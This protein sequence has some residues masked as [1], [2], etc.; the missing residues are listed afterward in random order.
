MD[1]APKEMPIWPLSLL[2]ELI[3]RP[4]L[5]IFRWLLQGEKQLLY[6]YHQSSW[7]LLAFYLQLLFTL[8]LNAIV[9]RDYLIKH[10]LIWFFVLIRLTISKCPKSIG[11]YSVRLSLATPS[12][13]TQN[14]SYTYCFG[15]D[16][17]PFR[18]IFHGHL[19]HA[20][21]LRMQFRSGQHVPL[22]QSKP[23]S[24]NLVPDTWPRWR[25]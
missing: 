5:E 25:R 1:L 24:R 7:L 9:Y 6:P 10:V 18:E 19:R 20:R 22:Q 21:K 13:N 15:F 8:Y 14:G 4:A 2:R 3:M 17:F 12:S 16:I 23:R 11:T